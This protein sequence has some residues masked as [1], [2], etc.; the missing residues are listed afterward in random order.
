MDGIFR[1]QKTTPTNFKMYRMKVSEVRI[2]NLVKFGNQICK[3]YEINNSNFYVRNEEIDESL[4]S[5]WANIEPIPLTEEWLLKF[6]FD[7]TKE[8]EDFFSKTKYKLLTKG[9]LTF[10]YYPMW[11]GIENKNYEH[12]KNVHQLQNLYFALTNEELT[13]KQ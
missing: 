13:L 5:T 9:A 1:T 3:V 4:K 2:G 7:E 12:I 11:N 8:M 6:G 10:W